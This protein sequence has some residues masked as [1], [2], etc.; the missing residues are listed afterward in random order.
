MST[1]NKAL[2]ITFAQINP[3]V[4]DISGNAR[5]LL[6][7][8]RKQ[9]KDSDLVIF[10]E[11]FLCG[12]P[13]EDLVLNSGFLDMIK[14]Q[15]KDICMRS[16]DFPSAALI[17][18]VWEEDNT[19]FN[20]AL[21]VEHG[22]LKHIFYKH[23]LPNN[24]V[25]D[26]PRTFSPGN[27]PKPLFFRGHALGIMICE[28]VW[29][30]E[31]PQYLK[32]NG[33]EVLIAI[34]GSPFH[35]YQDQERRAVALEA[36][37]ATGLDLVYLN[38]VGGQDELVFD[39]RS[40][41][42]N[43]DKS[44]AYKAPAFEEDIFTISIANEVSLSSS[45]TITD[46][47]ESAPKLDPI[48][49]KYKALVTGMRD[50]V[51]KNGFSNVIIGLSGG[52]DSALTAALA[53]DAFGANY[54]RCIMMPSKFTS[55]ASIEDAKQCSNMLNVSYET[56]PI[57]DIIKNFEE[58]VP[59]LYGS[60]VAQENTQSRVRG[61][62]LMALSNMANEMLITTGN[63]SEMAVG[64]CTI[65]G[66]MNGGFNA[67][68]DIYKTDVYKLAEWR[69]QQSVVIPESILTKAPTA[70]LR[71]DQTDQDSLPPYDLLDDILKLLIDYDN[72]NWDSA[73]KVLLEMRERCL[74]HPKE[75]KRI[76]T[77]LKNTEYKR[78]QSAPGTRISYRAFGRD[79]RYPL[80]NHF[81]N[82]IEKT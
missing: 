72:V 2:K 52:I 26:E 60:G 78:F 74:E 55:G 23:K 11:L 37:D 45:V 63:K 79:R 3:T 40:F 17:P 77:M 50:Y 28:D 54:V 61:T 4:G 8:W 59:T 5:L 64:Y 47:K 14:R 69:N 62:I 36:V 31:V 39:G 7:V 53:V 1:E 15:V 70:E 6:D 75:V 48:E 9:G 56:I 82:K 21:L 42:I 65:Y 71:K 38:M 20:A 43:K 35:T 22:K 46:N 66:D 25:F 67:L 58:T 12:Y 19:H 57:F 49:L 81:V 80:T 51:N 68:K 27:A 73:P 16:S 13:P 33:A 34:N 44:I 18:T 41:V 29:H 24:Y 30:V 76:A 10:P 32:N